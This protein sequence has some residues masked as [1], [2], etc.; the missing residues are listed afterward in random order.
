MRSILL[1]LIFFLSGVTLA[2]EGVILKNTFS[3]E[4]SIQKNTEW[5]KDKNG[6]LTI[7]DVHNGD[8]A[9]QFNRNRKGISNFGYSYLPYWI[10]IPF[11]VE[12]KPGKLLFLKLSYPHIDKIDFHLIDKKD[13]HSIVKTGDSFPFSERKI[14]SRYFL[15]PLPLNK[16]DATLYIRLQ[17]TGAMNFPL[18]IIDV[19]TFHLQNR[20]D[21]LAQGLLFGILLIMIFY[22]FFIYLSVRERVYLFYVAHIS[23]LT[24]YLSHLNGFGNEYLWPS[25]PYLNNIIDI[26]STFGSFLTVGLFIIDYLDTRRVVPRLNNLLAAFT[27]FPGLCMILSLFAQRKI[28]LYIS[29]I[30]PILMVVLLILIAIIASRK[31]VRQ[32]YFFLAAWGIVMIAAGSLALSRLGIVGNNFLIS[33]SLPIGVV[34]NVVFLSL[35]LADRINRMKTELFE[36]NIDLEGKVKERT[37]QLED[38]LN[39]IEVTNERL[40]ERNDELITAQRIRRKDMAMAISVQN[41]I[42]PDSPQI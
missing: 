28:L 21:Q 22:N 8:A 18:S 17:S 39:E 37:H 41:S 5:L 42:L 24:L 34:F 7:Q 27:V 12:E 35:G 23:F 3:G 31:K 9:G 36:L 2:A 14:K 25:M 32:A 30:F 13:H 40:T 11:S 15:F 29:S 4:I 16:G 10:K 1:T 38:A 33:Y 26:F 20:R 6:T 19:E